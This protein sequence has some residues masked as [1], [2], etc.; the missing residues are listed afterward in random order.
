[1]AT[2]FLAAA[3]F[4]AAPLAEAPFAARGGDDAFVVVR[5]EPSLPAGLGAAGAASGATLPPLR[6]GASGDAA[7]SAGLAAVLIELGSGAGGGLELRVRG[8]MGAAVRAPAAGASGVS[9]TLA[10]TSAAFAP[11][12]RELTAPELSLPEAA[13][14]P[15][16]EIGADAAALE[17]GTGESARKRRLLSQTGVK[18]PD[19]RSTSPTL[20]LAGLLDSMSRSSVVMVAPRADLADVARRRRSMPA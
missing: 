3:P 5:G 7:L 15:R 1:L 9:P 12:W 19:R 17:A 20:K 18:K 13:P 8:A 14:A 6:A 10:W 16:D 11:C 4:A 2:A